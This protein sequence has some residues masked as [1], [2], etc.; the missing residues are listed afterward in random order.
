MKNDDKNNSWDAWDNYPSGSGNSRRRSGNDGFDDPFSKSASRPNG[1]YSDREYEESRR[2]ADNSDDISKMTRRDVPSRVSPKQRKKNQ[3]KSRRKKVL[4]TLGAIFFVAVIVCTGM[5]VGMY[6]AVKSEIKDMNIK[7]LA[8]NQT[9]IIYC[10]NSDGKFEE[11]ESIHGDGGNRIYTDN[12][13][14]HVKD[15]LVS[16]EDERFYSHHGVDLKRTLGA[17]VKYALSKIGIGSANYGGSTITQQVIKNITQENTKTPT[18]KIKEML[19][20]I[21]LENELNDKDQIL[22]MYLNIAYFSSGCYGIEAAAQ[23]YYGK[24]TEDLSI[25]EAASIVGITQRPAYYDPIKHPD[26]N[27]KKRNTVLAKMLELN[28]ITQEEYD[29]AVST[30]VEVKKSASDNQSKVSSYFVDMVIRDLILDLQDKKGYTESFATKQVYNGGLKIY[31]TMDE[32]IQDKMEEVYEDTSNFPQADAQSAMII[33]D[34]HNGEIKGVV[35]GIGEKTTIRGLNRA[36]QS[37]R[38]P[39]SAIKPLSI[40]TPAIEEG[41]KQSASEQTD[42][43]DKA[44]DVKDGTAFTEA[45]IVNDSPR[46]FIT[47]TKEEWK[48]SNSYSSPVGNMTAKQAL[49]ISSNVAAAAILEDYLGGPDT[50]YKYLE[51]KFHISTLD[52]SSDKALSPMSLGGLTYGVS[53]KELAAAYGVIANEGKYIKPYSYTKVEDA[54]GDVILENKSSSSQVISASTAYIMSDML[55]EVVNGTDPHATGTKAKIPSQNTYG[56]TGTTND[57]YDKWFVG[58]TPYYVAAAWYGFDEPKAISSSG[59]PALTAWQQVMR[60]VHDGLDTKELPKPTNV[61]S[62]KICKQTGLKANSGCPSTVCYFEEGTSIKDCTSHSGSKSLTSKATAKPSGASGAATPKPLGDSDSNIPASTPA[63]KPN[64]GAG[65]P[66]GGSS[67]NSSSGASSGS[68][69][70]EEDTHTGSGSQSGGNTSSAEES[71][72]GGSANQSSATAVPKK[73]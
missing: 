11:Y 60:S 15:A 33:I 2:R 1:L 51:D 22:N 68:S 24:S 28:K 37:K 62:E 58:F 14:Q 13:P 23:T 61:F 21:A 67:G 6:T 49:E 40:Y 72:S 5:L 35:G 48:P 12:I 36:V 70:H 27:E 19:R 54:S 32:D 26:N 31:I 52:E 55:Y 47:E 43:S 65:T 10:K 64:A 29:K 9:S 17:T 45:T 59:N 7:T 16:I 69:S 18:R 3:K 39:G 41:K 57:D 25:A 44:S 56:K 50:S 63:V 73:T 71:N 8:L 38:Q 30:P 20:A 34:Y 46:T 4:I 66:S 53:P 42:S